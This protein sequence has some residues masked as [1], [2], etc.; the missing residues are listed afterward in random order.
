VTPIYL[1]YN[2]TAPL[3]EASHAAMTA[4]LR[5]T[6]NASSV[7][8]AGRQARRLIE[9]AREAVAARIGARPAGVIFTSG[10]TEANN[11]ALSA[12]PGRR[13]LASAVEHPSVLKGEIDQIIPVDR[14]GVVDLA[15]LEQAVSGPPALVSVMLANNETGVIQP[16]AEIAR[17]ARRKGALL[18]VDAVQAFGKLPV[19]IEALGADLLSLSAHKIGGP[20]GVGALI[21]RDPDLDIAPRAFGGGQE[22]RHRAGT[23]NVAGIAGFGAAVGELDDIEA[24]A[25]HL[26]RLRDLVEESCRAAVPRLVR[27]GHKVR[28]LSNTSCFAIPGVPAQTLLM[29]LDLEAVAVSAGSACSSGKLAPSGVLIAMGEE[30]LAGSAIRVSMGW[31][32][33]KMEIEEF[34]ERFLRVAVHL[35]AE[36]SA[37]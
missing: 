24:E 6:G 28:R 11:M 18:H 2:A 30:A 32:T 19:D 22:G 37:A 17:L 35:A 36:H 7:H 23:E 31:A 4:A 29:A 13:I 3:R 27:F 20:Q 15:A 12:F 33:T 5:L 10:G 34:G 1:D 14:D 21:R 25:A 16:I 26:A 9:E 8:R